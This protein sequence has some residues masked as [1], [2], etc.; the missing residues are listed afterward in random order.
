MKPFIALCIVCCCLYTQGKPESTAF[1]QSTPNM[2]LI[3]LDDMGY[4]ELGSYGQ[5][6]I[7]TPRMDQ[8]AAEGL[9]FTNFYAGNTVCAPSRTSLMTGRH[10]GHCAVRGNMGIVNGKWERVGIGAEDY[11][12]AEM[13]KKSGYATGLIGKWHLE[14]PGD[15]HSYPSHHGFDFSI[16]EHWSKEILDEDR[17]R[18]AKQGWVYDR[19]YLD[20]I[21]LND[22]PVPVPENQ[23]GQHTL[24]LDELNIRESIRF[25]QKHKDKPFFLVMSL[26]TPHEPPS[27][28]WDHTSYL[29]KGWP[30]L[31]RR[32]AARITWIDAKIG[33]IIDL[34]DD[35]GL[36]EKT[37]IFLTSDNGG[38]AEGGH[39][40]EF[41]NSNG[42]LRGIKRDLYEGGIRVPHIVRWKGVV[43]PGRVSDHISA[44][45]D[46]MPTF[47]EIAGQQPPEQT[48]GISFLPLI[49]DRPQPKHDYLYWEFQLDGFFQALP[50]G[51]FRQAVRKGPWKAVRHKVDGPIELY[52]LDDDPSESMD[53][54][55]NHPALIVEMGTILKNSRSESSRYP[56]GGKIVL[57]PENP[58]NIFK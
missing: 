46:Y 43:K 18:Y 4:G 17:A 36:G 49:L 29:E 23:N 22:V 35:L 33:Q 16:R 15:E 7:A 2:V 3:L 37:V 11:T 47:A 54:S 44:F 55:K 56:Y 21:Y 9:R 13:L 32:H 51:G 26:K 39:K 34:I 31:E 42:P 50:D 30:E 25:I 1:D 57:E 48:D 8:L 53:V 10:P 24:I 40:A 14:R 19:N 45:W 12:I 58:R 27:M 20:T 52:H 6:K 41:F 28:D 38:H 5:V